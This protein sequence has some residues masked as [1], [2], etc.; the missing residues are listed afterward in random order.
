MQYSQI[1]TYKIGDLKDPLVQ[2][3]YC[4]D[5]APK[6]NMAT[7]WHGFQI[8]PK[9]YLPCIPFRI[10]GAKAFKKWNKEPKGQNQNDNEVRISFTCM[11]AFFFFFIDTRKASACQLQ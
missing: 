7:W 10:E 5:K 2:P 6:G 1:I 11:K 4:S 9:T 8:G 3:P